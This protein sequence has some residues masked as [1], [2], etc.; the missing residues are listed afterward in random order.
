MTSPIVW[1][2]AASVG[3]WAA[4][5]LVLGPES[6]GA[7]SVGSLGPLV[8]AVATWIVVERL[9]ARKPEQVSSGMIKLLAA[10]MLFFGVY[11]AAAV[12]LLPMPVRA[13]VVSFT[14]QYIML[15]FIEALFLRRLFAAPGRRVGVD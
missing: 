4:L 14:S 9:H 2:G 6:R 1:M 13:F 12:T 3:C 5:S 15:H 8:A 11:V 10:K 7:V